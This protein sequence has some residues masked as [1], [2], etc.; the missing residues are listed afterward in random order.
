[1]SKYEDIKDHGEFKN[2]NSSVL[3]KLSLKGLKWLVRKN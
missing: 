2:N 1:M 3:T